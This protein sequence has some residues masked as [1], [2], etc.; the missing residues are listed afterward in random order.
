MD[1]L[2]VN[3]KIAR[4]NYKA[5]KARGDAAACRRYLDEIAELRGRRKGL[6]SLPSGNP[7]VY[8]GRSPADKLTRKWKAEADKIKKSDRAAEDPE[9]DEIRWLKREMDEAR[10]GE[11][12]RGA[13]EKLSK[14]LS[15]DELSDVLTANSAEEIVRKSGPSPRT[16]KRQTQ[17][18]VGWMVE[19]LADRSIPAA[20]RNE[21]LDRLTRAAA[22]DPQASSAV[23]AIAGKV[24]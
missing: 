14:M 19:R 9:L 20:E 7:L 6:K 11:T 12:R 17:E 8:K 24:R 21:I 23:A 22:N 4:S 16:T 10:D 18:S 3:L 15:P 13:L 2:K 1:A 5:A